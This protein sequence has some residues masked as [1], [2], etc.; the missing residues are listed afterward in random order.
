[1]IQYTKN[2][3]EIE[4]KIEQIKNKR[5]SENKTLNWCGQLIMQV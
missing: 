2:R 4:Q 1:M 3:A 5:R